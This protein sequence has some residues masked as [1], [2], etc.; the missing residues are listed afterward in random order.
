MLQSSRR[1][2][3]DAVF[4]EA[5]DTGKDLQQGEWLRFPLK[6]SESPAL[7]AKAAWNGF[8]PMSSSRSRVL[9]CK[10]HQSRCLLAPEAVHVGRQSRKRAAQFR[11]SVDQA[12]PAVVEAIQKHTWT[13]RPGDCWLTSEFAEV[14][15]AV[16]QLPDSIRRGV[17]FHSVE[18]WHTES[19]TLAA[20]EVG[21][22]VGA[23]YT[24]ATGF[25]LKD[26]F[27]GA[28]T[29]QLV[30]LGKLLQRCGFRLWDLGMAVDY[31]LQLGAKMF[32]R[33]S[34][35]ACVRRLRDM[36]VV[37]SSAAVADLSVKELLL[38]SSEDGAED[39]AAAGLKPSSEADSST[40][41]LTPTSRMIQESL[42][43]ATRET[44]ERQNVG[45]GEEAPLAMNP[46]AG[47]RKENSCSLH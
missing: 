28:G 7:I 24:S 29:V 19:G 13:N 22:T 31:K 44:P 20:G 1:R 43:L 33:A 25:A 30:A 14:Y 46:G 35:I 42:L 10:L 6:P 21:Y 4:A 34:W 17:T 9:L 15:L 11:I 36:R 3:A 23:I 2:D 16:M 40:G 41:A 38:S 37:L 32:P 12:F 8:L 26:E 5:A 47:K 45:R 27:P 18:L 39:D